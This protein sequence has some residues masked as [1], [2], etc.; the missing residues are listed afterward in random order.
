MNNNLEIK[1]IDT[2]KFFTKYWKYL[3]IAIFT[4]GLSIR[5]VFL[6]VN[7]PLSLDALSY[8]WYAFDTKTLGYFPSNYGFPNTGWSEWLSLIF[9]VNPSIDILDYMSL[10]RISSVVIS[11]LTVFPIFFFC[12]KYFKTPIALIGALIFTVEPHIILNSHLGITEPIFILFVV[13]AIT[14]LLS[15]NKKLIYFG[16]L[17]GGVAALIR[18]EGLVFL[19]IYSAIFFITH[20]HDSKK[21]VKYVL[22]LSIFIIILIPFAYLRIENIQDDGLTSHIIAGIEAPLIITENEDNQIYALLIFVFIGIQNLLKYTGWVM[23]PYFFILAPIGTIIFLKNKN[24]NKAIFIFSVII[25][26][27][28]ALY[29]Y[30]RGIQETRYLLIL[31]PFFT[32]FSLFLFEKLFEKEKRNFLVIGI[33]FIVI[34][35]SILYIDYKK[36]DG[37]YENEAYLIS[38]QIGKIATN[39]NEFYPESRYLKIA[40]I[41]NYS[42]PI[43]SNEIPK[44]NPIKTEGYDSIIDFINQNE[45]NGLSHLVIDNKK[46]R[47][48][49]IREVFD[50][51]IKYPFLTKIFDSDDHDYNY[52][53]KIFEI[54]YNKFTKFILE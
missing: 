5:L 7:A 4:I 3:L 13:S 23:I 45:K 46:D 19:P 35:S 52:R 2:D 26:S 54:D 50:D 49:F 29:A 30:S 34:I 12:K 38:K 36:I 41:E 14:S 25:L 42:Y 22:A 51:E 47:I 53:V 40:Y 20:K 32:V 39:V 44:I 18:Y 21:L 31:I 33:L 16:F 24:K 15:K 17:L 10:Q 9:F 43:L 37:G 6:P 27:I 48:E 28:P 1:E 8:F 11:S